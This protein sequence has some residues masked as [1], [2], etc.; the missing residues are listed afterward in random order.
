MA[1]LLED[2][3]RSLADQVPLPDPAITDRVVAGVIESYRA[4]LPA[5]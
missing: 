3:L 2:R 5:G 4:E 1:T